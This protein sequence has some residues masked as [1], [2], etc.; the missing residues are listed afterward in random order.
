MFS[1]FSNKERTQASKQ[2]TQTGSVLG[3]HQRNDVADRLEERGEA[4][5]AMLPNAVPVRVVRARSVE[6]GNN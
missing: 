2:A 4:L 5:A 3:V 6:L 1:K